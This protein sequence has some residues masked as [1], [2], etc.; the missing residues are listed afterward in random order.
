MAKSGETRAFRSLNS[1]PDCAVEIWDTT[2]LPPAQAFGL[3]RD[4]VRRSFMPWETEVVNDRTFEARLESVRFDDGLIG[5]IRSTPTHGIRTKAHI[6]ESEVE[7]VYASLRLFGDAAIKQGDKFVVA[8]PGDLVIFDS[9]RPTVHSSLGDSNSDAIALLIPRKAL[10]VQTLGSPCLLRKHQIMGPLSSCMDYITQNLSSLSRDELKGLFDACVDMLPVAAGCYKISQDSPPEF[11]SDRSLL[12]DIFGFVDEHLTSSELT[13][14]S[15][16]TNFGISERYVHKLFS[17]RGITCSHYVARRR[18]E[19][20]R[21]DLLNPSLR[22][23]PIAHVAYR[24]GFND[25]ST[26]NKAF[27]KLFGCSPRQLRT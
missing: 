7:C 9:V 18:L 4:G 12:R 1:S 13:A 5:R 2:Y 21:V 23:E 24:W 10:A 15:I 3:F 17:R 11:W 20:I 26:F 16:A 27:R 25:L 6:A 22:R 8:R 19:R 14:K